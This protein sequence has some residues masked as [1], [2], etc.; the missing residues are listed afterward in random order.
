MKTKTT[1]V[2][3]LFCGLSSISSAFTLNFTG[4]E[5]IE[6]PPDVLEIPVAGYGSVRFE[7]VS[8]STLIVDSAHMN[9]D[10]T[11]APSL[12]FQPSES[13]KVTFI[14]LKPSNVN[15]DYVGVAPGE[16][17]ISEA[18]AV[19]PQAFIVTMKGSGEGAGLYAVSWSQIPEP[20][21]AVLG[22][23]A[24]AVCIFRRRR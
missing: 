15:F 19:T 24:G 9:D 3:A 18:D 23:L 2:A 12:S 21:S 4:Y 7:A 10:G 17:F 13:V 22:V 5:G 8:G 6:L 1:L 16:Y 20:S 14:G 11:A